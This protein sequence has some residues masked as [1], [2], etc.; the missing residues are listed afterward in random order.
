[1][2]RRLT[3]FMLLGIVGQLWAQLPFIDY[4]F[5]PAIPNS[6]VRKV[7]V[8]P[9]GKILVGGGFFGYGGTTQGRLVRL[10]PDGSLDPSFNP[11][12]SGPGHVVHDIALMPDGRIIIGGAFTTYN[13]VQVKFVTRL[14][15]NG[16]LDPSWNGNVALT[17]PV[18]AVA[19]HV[20]N[21]I[22]AAGEFNNCSGV[23]APHIV[24]FT[25]GG[26]RD[27]T[28]DHGTGLN[29]FVND[30]E[31]L[32][33]MRVLAVGQFMQYKGNPATRVVRIHPNG[34]H[35]TSLA[36][37]DPL[38]P[39]GT[40]N[41]IAVQPDGRM[42]ISGSFHAYDTAR[43]AGVLRLHP[44]GTRD[45][46][47]RS[48]LANYATAHSVTIRPDGSL[49]LA[50]EWVGTQVMPGNPDRAG[51]LSLHANGDV[52]TQFPLGQGA[53]SGG[54]GMAFV[55]STALQP[56]GRVLAGGF[57]GA[58]DNETQYMHLIR[59]QQASSLSIDDDDTRPSLTLREDPLHGRLIISPPFHQEGTA[60]IRILTLNGQELV[61][62][63]HRS[64]LEGPLVIDAHSLPQAPGIY[65][66]TWDQNGLFAAAKWVRVGPMDR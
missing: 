14:L 45:N 57:F 64:V 5:Q 39:N 21:S 41:G 31:V 11:G 10:M 42:I 62:K 33:D 34:D 12:G 49:L 28:F 32:P 48:P 60:T 56:D 8:Q 66:I 61:S 43:I 13:G 23:S 16:T 52:D 20:E 6:V 44:D 36:T 47:F 35:D 17:A 7:V 26:E 51:I 18:R 63:R 1:M 30:L 54:L 15:P 58:F 65:L 25:Y 22:I 27:T 53:L 3:L 29:S 37:V 46:T 19:L 4:G 59:L 2:H 40:V 55:R 9:D 24:R 38:F 50:G